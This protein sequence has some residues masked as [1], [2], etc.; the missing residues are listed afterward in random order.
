MNDLA[1]RLVAD[2]LVERLRT[3]DARALDLAVAG[4][5]VGLQLHAGEV[6]GRLVVLVLGP[7]LERMVVALV[8]IE[9]HGQEQ[10]RGGLHRVGRLAKDLEVRGGRILAVRSGGG[11]DLLDELV[12]GRVGRQLA[13]NPLPQGG[14]PF[15]P[16]VLA[17]DLQQVGPLVRP[18]LD[19]VVAADQP[20]DHL[21]ALVRGVAPIVEKRPHLG[22]RR[23]QAGQIQ[24]DAAE[25]LGIGTQAPRGGSS[26]AA[27]W[28]RPVRRSCPRFPAPAR[29]SRC[30]RP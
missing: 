22:G 24:I 8:A 25:E 21:V 29:Q 15:R 28:R 9:P 7:T 3:F 6:S 11:E 19:E 26:S 18:V 27:T 23:R 30:G 16:Q 5:R 14:G 17:I 10:V 1:L 20:V 13:A 4:G 2:D 12:V